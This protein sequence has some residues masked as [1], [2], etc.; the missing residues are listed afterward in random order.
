MVLLHYARVYDRLAVRCVLPRAFS[1]FVSLV[2]LI[3][4]LG[5]Y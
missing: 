1:M 5:S 3:S 4:K 2:P